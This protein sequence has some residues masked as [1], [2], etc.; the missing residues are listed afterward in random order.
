MR[1]TKSFKLSLNILLHSKL[2]S[3]LTIIGIII[4]IAAVV[5]IMSIS[6]GA[7]QQLESR[8][9]TFGADII[10]ITP[11]FS[12]A[13]GPGNFGGG[14][15]G[16]EGESSSIDTKNLTSKDVLMLKNIPNVKYI[17][18]Q[19]SGREDLTYMT[20][21]A[22]LSITGIDT[23]VWKDITTEQLS[24][25]RFLTSGDSYSVVLG[26]DVVSSTFEDGI[27][28]NSK[29]T[30]GGKSFKVVGILEEG[31]GAYV[32]L[33]VARNVL[34]DASGDKFDSIS[35]QL[36]DISLSNETITTIT[37]RLMLSHGIID[38]SKKDFTV[39][40]PTSMQETIQQT[41]DTMTLFLGAI[42]AISLIVGAVGIANTMFTS[43]LEKTKEIG[44]MKAI[45]AQDKDIMTIFLLNSALIGLIGGVGGVLLGFFAST[46]ISSFGGIQTAVGGGRGMMGGFGSS[47][48]VSPEL[49][50]GAL[51][52]S[53]LVGMLAGAIPAYR[54]S[55][56]N[57]VDALRS[58]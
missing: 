49:I 11:G 58:E 22:T 29:V 3:W 31:R 27:P 56:L 6:E 13:M 48:Y 20:K 17:L 36:E 47:T 38:E 35:V 9:G 16:F 21:T 30:I 23:T 10:T 14:R 2:R 50:I 44:I 46:A 33:D 40:S 25:G 18:G 26:G 42:A 19:I 5:S 53:V 41:M 37:E 4:G 15:G 28:L 39:S 54:A 45:G 55:K 57:P 12:R 8:L 7:Q 51:L 52:F 32:P 1:L 24:S 34:E 43:V